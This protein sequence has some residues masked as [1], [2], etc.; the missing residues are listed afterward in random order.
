VS[1]SNCSIKD[2]GDR[3]SAQCTLRREIAF[4]NGQ[5]FNR[6]NA[7]TFDLEKRGNDWVIKGLN[8][9]D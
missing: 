5:T 9:R 8:V 3:A 2:N 1:L 6:S 4:K 7:A